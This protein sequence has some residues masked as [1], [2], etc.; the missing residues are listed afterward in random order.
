MIAIFSDLQEVAPSSIIELFS[1][2]LIQEIHGTDLEYRFY[3]STLTYPETNL[4]WN[5]VEY[6]AIPIQAS[7]FKYAGDGQLP[8]PTLK[9]SNLLGT[10]TSILLGIPS[11]LEGAR[12]TRIRTLLRYL[13]ASN[14]P[15]NANPYGTPDPTAEMPREVYIIDRKAN[16]NRDVV[17]FE[18]ATVND[19]QG[20]RIPKRQ[21]ISSICQWVYKS[22]EC[23]Y[24]GS[25]QTCKKTLSDCRAHF[26][27]SAQLPFGGFP[28][29]GT[30][31]S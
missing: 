16:E 21:C 12:V 11:G 19:L 23:S 9:I 2:E 27:A 28:G 10:V 24:L 8:R 18:L 26:G 15:E 29:V 31:I 13:D 14:F 3:D 22:P 1:L 5:G 7:G 17:E 4:T 30:Y 25:L 20:I 6:D